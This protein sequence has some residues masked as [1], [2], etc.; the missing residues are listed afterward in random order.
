MTL[1]RCQLD[2]LPLNGDVAC[3]YQSL[4][5]VSMERVSIVFGSFSVHRMRKLLMHS[6]WL[7]G[8]IAPCGLSPLVIRAPTDDVGW[9]VSPV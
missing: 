8:H 1:A 5:G 4:T 2:A 7:S 3:R 9:I 6:V